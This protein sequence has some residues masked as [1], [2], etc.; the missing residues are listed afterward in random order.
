MI[1]KI[2][3]VVPIFNANADHLREALESIFSQTF[4]D[5]EVLVINDGS[6]NP[7][8][9]PAAEYIKNCANP[10]IRLIQNKTRL[11]LIDSLNLGVREARG[12]F[13]ARMDGDDVALPNRFEKQL[14]YLVDH[15]EIDVLG[16][17]FVALDDADC[18]WSHPVTPEDV[19]TELLCTGCVIGHPTVMM[20]KSLF[21]RFGVQYDRTFI[22]SEDYA[23]WATLSTK[24]KLTNLPDVLLKYRRHE[25][26]TS[27]RMRTIVGKNTARVKGM[28]AA[29]LFPERETDI[30]ALFEILFNPMPEHVGDWKLLAELGSLLEDLVRRNRKQAL[31][32]SKRFESF[33]TETWFRFWS[34]Q[35]SIGK[36]ALA[37]YFKP[38][39]GFRCGL[40]PYA[41]NT[42]M[43]ARFSKN[44][45]RRA[46]NF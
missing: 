15:P 44:Q 9:D 2:S 21:D 1:P 30:M 36:K 24:T 31:Y 20:R 32:P 46:L 5:Y 35:G 12:E 23:L 19:R 45:L 38:R 6:G 34:I 17:Q 16:S 13:I 11:G 33:L 40:K 4:E 29:Q 41:L 22:H 39:L 7:A 8:D 37:L 43:L 27:M 25:D 3:V 42:Y 10:K 28:L 26:Q 18:V 14:K